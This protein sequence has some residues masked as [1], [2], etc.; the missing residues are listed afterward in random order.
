[1]ALLKIPYGSQAWAE[2]LGLG[3]G[4]GKRGPQLFVYILKAVN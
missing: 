2:N 4:I 1:M 3:G